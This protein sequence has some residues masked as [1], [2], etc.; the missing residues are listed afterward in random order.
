MFKN[1]FEPVISMSFVEVAET[2][3]E[4]G[5]VRIML[6]ALTEKTWAAF[7]LMPENYPSAGDVFLS[8]TV[9]SDA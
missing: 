2:D 8:T 7:A 1:M 3:K 5:S 6:G 9:A 4:Q